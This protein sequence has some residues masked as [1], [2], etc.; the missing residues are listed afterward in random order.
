MTREM[1]SLAALQSGVT[2]LPACLA[3][4]LEAELPPLGKIP[5]R[6]VTTGIGSSEAPARILANALSESGIA[7]RFCCA[8]RFVLDPPGGDLLVVFSQGLSPNARLAL[9]DDHGF[10]NRWLVTS[11]CAEGADDEALSRVEALRARGVKTIVVPPAREHGMLVR[12]VGPTVAT[13]VALR[14]G[15]TLA[16][17][18][19]MLAKLAEAPSVYR[20]TVEAGTVLGGPMALVTAGIPAE[21]AHAQR[22][23]LLEGLLV[24]DPPVWDV[25][26]VA[27]GP[28][29]SFHDWPMTLLVLEDARA[30]SLVDRLNE[31]LVPGRHRT[32]RLVTSRGDA[33]SF[34]EHA[35]S[36]DALL[37]ATLEASPRDLYDWPARGADGPLYRI[38]EG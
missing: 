2:N 26:Q 34:F 24:R 8:S 3:A 14:I 25:L 4:A 11:V 38:G 12:I 21:S 32:I 35:A 6:I 33:L 10:A 22:W 36:V 5:K 16:R 29:Q 23:K 20:S 9:G 1:D 13:L 27:H 37:L 7:A 30:S 19:R 17:D 28:L 31:T 18:E 15:A